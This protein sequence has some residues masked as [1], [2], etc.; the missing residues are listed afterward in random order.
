MAPQH[1][2]RPCDDSDD[3]RE[4]RSSRH[5][6]SE[7]DDESEL[8]LP[9]LY[10]RLSCDNNNG[11]TLVIP[12]HLIDPPFTTEPFNLDLDLDESDD[13]TSQAAEWVF[14][15]DEDEDEDDD[16]S[17]LCAQ[18]DNDDESSVYE[19]SSTGTRAKRE[20]FKRATVA[21]KPVPAPK[22]AAGRRVVRR[23]AA[24]AKSVEP[25]PI[26]HSDWDG[27]F[28]CPGSHESVYFMDEVDTNPIFCC[29]T[30]KG[31]VDAG[32]NDGR[33][34]WTRPF[35]GVNESEYWGVIT[36]RFPDSDTPRTFN[37]YTKFHLTLETLY[38]TATKEYRRGT[39]RVVLYYDLHQHTYPV[40]LPYA[41]CDMHKLVSDFGITSGCV[42]DVTRFFQGSRVCRPIP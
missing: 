41:D 10:D 9:S 20:A 12:N 14:P 39:K 37:I 26:T 3:E 35:D 40:R 36:L 32:L 15:P 8:S 22:I 23:P 1:T 11:S 30:L 6:N 2:K 31:L 7:N 42:I 25:T 28:V 21:I 19:L 18:S 13:N 5:T 33:T 4:S 24:L 16:I 17:I 27:L 38:K 34:F 29:T